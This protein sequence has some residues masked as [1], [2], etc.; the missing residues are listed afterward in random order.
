MRELDLRVRSTPEHTLSRP[1][2][3]AFEEATDARG[4]RLEVHLLHLPRRLT[5]SEDEAGAIENTSEAAARHAGD[6]L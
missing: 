5:L 4:R 6:D 2:S 1:R 3:S